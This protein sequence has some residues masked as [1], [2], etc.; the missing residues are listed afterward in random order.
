M[1][2]DEQLELL[3]TLV[4][5][6]RQLPKGQRR[7]FYMH[8]VI[9]RTGNYMVVHPSPPTDFQGAYPAD[10][11]LLSNHGLIHLRYS[12]NS[13]SAD[14]TPE[15]FDYYAN[16]KH[17]SR[18]PAQTVETALRSLLDDA[19]LQNAFGPAI[20]KWRQAEDLLWSADVPAEFT[21]IGHHCREVMQLFAAAVEARFGSTAGV[22]PAKTVA[23]IRKILDARI[24]SAGHRAFAE[25]L[26]SYW[27][28]VSDL[29]QRQEHGAF[30]DERPLCWH[31]ARRLVFQTLLVM[32]ELNDV[33]DTYA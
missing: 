15:G 12:G 26:L 17:G 31:A 4:E 25:A 19:T 7:P 23:R 11:D 28:T 21:T 13:I 24:T 2:G 10:V 22:D 16:S 27:G 8:A 32:Y 29:A 3:A 5:A 20:A 1:L 30:K 9:N 14:I 33:L 18:T 6:S